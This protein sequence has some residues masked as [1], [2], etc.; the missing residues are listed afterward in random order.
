ML[1][2][3]KNKKIL[4]VVAHPD[5]ELLGLGGTINKLVNDYNCKARAVILGEGITSRSDSR[6]TDL[7]KK[8]LKK[9]KNNIIDAA[10]YIGYELVKT[11]NFPDNRFDSIDLLDIT[12]TEIMLF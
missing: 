6:N 1:E 5:D 9:H 10:K 2:S 11:H 4:V 8:E 7:W 12:V 3:L